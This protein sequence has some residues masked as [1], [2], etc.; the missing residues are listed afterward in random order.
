MAGSR[1][2]DRHARWRKT[3][4]QMRVFSRQQERL[5][6]GEEMT[7]QCDRPIRLN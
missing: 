4:S 3:Y 6:G 5:A 1:S 7:Q 2:T